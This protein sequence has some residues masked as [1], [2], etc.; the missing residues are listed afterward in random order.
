MRGPMSRQNRPSA[1]HA[2]DCRCGKEDATQEFDAKTA[3][4]R[5]AKKQDELAQLIAAHMASAPVPPSA[6]AFARAVNPPRDMAAAIQ[7]IVGGFPVGT[8]EF[9]ECC[10]IG[11]R[12]TNSLISWF[13]TG[14]LVHPRIVL[15]AGHC[16][17]PNAP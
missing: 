16:F 13:C 10:L 12:N 7:R 2:N 4:E 9:P 15:T 5:L 6:R 11:R 17:D 1:R 8:G 14:V 3:F